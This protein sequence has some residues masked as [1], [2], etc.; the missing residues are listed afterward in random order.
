MAGSRVTVVES[1]KFVL[2]RVERDGFAGLKRL[3]GLE[4]HRGGP[5]AVPAGAW[6]GRAVADGA[7]DGVHFVDELVHFAGR[8]GDFD[9]FYCGFGTALEFQPERRLEG[10]V[11]RA[12]PRRPD[13]AVGAGDL[14]G[15]MM[16]PTRERLRN[17]RVLPAG[18]V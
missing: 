7:D 2:L 6:D 11:H 8:V 10:P 18:K 3:L 12:A 14:R 15:L 13:G 17:H 1:P 9:V 5:P 4:A 16:F